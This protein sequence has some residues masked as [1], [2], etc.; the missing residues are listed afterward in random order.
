MKKKVLSAVF[1]MVMVLNAAGCGES[2][3]SDDID[4][5]DIGEKIENMSDDDIESAILD[6]VEK[7]EETESTTEAVQEETKPEVESYEPLQEIIDADFSS[8]LIQ[9]GD[10]IFKNGGYMT[11]NEF[12]EQYGDKYDTSEINLNGFI[13]ANDPY[14][15]TAT[16][17]KKN[18][19]I[20]L[21]ISYNNKTNDMIKMGDAVVF[22]VRNDPF[23]NFTI[24][25]TWYPTGISPADIFAYDEFVSFVEANGFT[26]VDRIT[27]NRESN[28]YI[29]SPGGSF[30]D[31]DTFEMYSET[32]GLNVCGKKTSVTYTAYFY[33]ETGEVEDFQIYSARFIEE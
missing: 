6:G 1:A 15:K 33:P 20:K 9:I 5:D 3:G 28:T 21:K 17:T 2:G 26:E 14:L 13:E 16:I 4:L 8:G 25:N 11:V 31:F 24:E 7:I 10:D 32:E 27:S 30:V 18:S 19:G 12:I 29:L 22:F 23:D